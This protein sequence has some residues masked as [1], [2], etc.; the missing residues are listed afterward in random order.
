MICSVNRV[1]RAMMGTLHRLGGAP[2]SA[3]GRTPLP[4]ARPDVSAETSHA[5]ASAYRGVRTGPAGC[6]NKAMAD[7]GW[8][9][10]WDE[11]M[12]GRGC[13]ICAAV[14]QGDTEWWVAVFTGEFA[15]VYLERRSRLPGYCI[16]VWKHGHI[17]EPAD[18]DPRQACGYWA[19]VLAVGR[20][21]RERFDPVKLNYLTLGN[22]VPHLHTHVVPRY[23]DD[24]APGGPIAWEDIFSSAPVPEPE[25]HRQAADLRLLLAT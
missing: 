8:P 21:V 16:V 18:L 17:A 10:D 13:P 9:E 4:P 19:E 6:F 5:M 12:A 14:G 24:P 20:A 2:P 25:L 3:E 22:T 7:R 23:R 1:P 11:R 15:E